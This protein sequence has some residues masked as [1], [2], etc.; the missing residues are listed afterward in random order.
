[1]HR[2]RRPH[3]QTNSTPR[4]RK[5]R[6]H[7]L[8]GIVLALLATTGLIVALARPVGDGAAATPAG[9]GAHR[10]HDGGALPAAP[11]AYRAQTPAWNH[12]PQGVVA[13]AQEAAT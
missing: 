8:H 4:R 13:G 12:L 1:M 10:A 9:P 7:R 2:R 5:M 3:S 11:A 6:K